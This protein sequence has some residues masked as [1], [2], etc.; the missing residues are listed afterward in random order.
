MSTATA[1]ALYAQPTDVTLVKDFLRPW[2]TSGDTKAGGAGAGAAAYVHAADLYSAD[3]EELARAFQPAVSRD[4][5]AVWYF[6]SP[7]RTKSPRDRRKVRAVA[8]GTGCWHSEA[9]PKNVID[10]LDGGRHV[11]YRQSFSFMRRRETGPDVRAGWVMAEFHLHHENLGRKVEGL[12]LCKMYRSPRIHGPAVVPDSDDIVH[13]DVSLYAE[14]MFCCGKSKAVDDDDDSY[15]VPPRWQRRHAMNS[16]R[17]A[18]A[19]AMTASLLKKKVDGD[20]AV[21]G[22]TM[23]AVPCPNNKVVVADDEDL[24]VLPPARKKMKVAVADA[25]SSGTA[26]A[27]KATAAGAPSMAAQLHCPQC[28]FHLAALQALVTLTKSKSIMPWSCPEEM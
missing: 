24:L 13:S 14:T 18:T 22:T 6:L 5:D 19:T 11:G 12:V 27:L 1:A 26:L 8:D 28:G 10:H 9:G 23:A 2:V 17:T 3:P 15:S 20:D 16:D 21:S 25:D 7:L 4:G